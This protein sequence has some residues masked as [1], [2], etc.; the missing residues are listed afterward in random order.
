[1]KIAILGTAPSFLQAPYGDPEWQIWAVP[2][3]F[4]I[5]EEKAARN[6]ALHRVYEFHS[7]SVM[8]ITCE[9]RKGFIEFAKGLGKD[10][11]LREKND[12]Y[13]EATVFDKDKYVKKHGRSPFSCSVSWMMAEAIDLIEQSGDAEKVIGIWGVNMAHDSEYVYQ[14]PGVR[15]MIGYAEAKGFKIIVPDSSELMALH[16]LYGFEEVPPA[17]KM[18][19]ERMKELNEKMAH[20]DRMHQTEVQAI[21]YFNGAL[22]EYEVIDAMKNISEASERKKALEEAIRERTEASQKSLMHVHVFMGAREEHQWV[23]NNFFKAKDAG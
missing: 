1:M 10:F 16:C 8:A 5:E 2:G 7:T 6:K 23:Q 17:F 13:P 22:K 14:K 19:Q 15:H 12:N 20:H 11:Y 21:N 3:C 9:P 18:I 4:G